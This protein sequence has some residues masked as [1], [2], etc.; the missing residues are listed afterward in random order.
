M[1]LRSERVLHR[2]T[3]EEVEWALRWGREDGECRTW[4]LG[5]EEVEVRRDVE[6]GAE[7]QVA[8][9]G[10]LAAL[11]GGEAR[12]GVRV[13]A[14]TTAADVDR[15]AGELVASVR[16]ERGRG[17]GAGGGVGGRAVRVGGGVVVRW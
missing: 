12:V 3:E 13:R 11:G 10:R 5:V 15:C 6:S 7:G 8:R 16:G 14:E 9:Q 2:G 1:V 17:V 4:G